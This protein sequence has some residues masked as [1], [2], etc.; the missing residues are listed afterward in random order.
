MRG[1]ELA[2]QGQMAL[3]AFLGFGAK[4]KSVAGSEKGF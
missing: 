2:A 1:D 4:S 3:L